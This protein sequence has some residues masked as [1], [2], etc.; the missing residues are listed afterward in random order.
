VQPHTRATAVAVMFFIL[1]LIGLGLGPTVIG[2]CSDLFAA[3]TYGAEST[4]A[5]KAVCPPGGADPTCLAAQAEG[6]RLSLLVTALVAVLAIGCF[7]L[8]RR[9]IREDLAK[10][11][12]AT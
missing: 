6:L 3:S 8:A 7:V 2:W 10:T 4:A 1:N 9:T 5:F 11:R 12:P